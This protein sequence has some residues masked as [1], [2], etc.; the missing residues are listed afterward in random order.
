MESDPSPFQKNWRPNPR[1]WVIGVLLLLLTLL[2]G[3]M[4]MPVCEPI[5]DRRPF[6][7]VM[8][9]E[10]RKARGEPFE[11][12]NGRWH[13]CKSRLARAFFF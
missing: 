6:E 9:L 4:F 12:K 11:K 2:V 8:S 13:V 10:Q 1:R 5:P 3:T 7:S